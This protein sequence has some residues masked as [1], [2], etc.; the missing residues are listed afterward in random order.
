MFK[1]TGPYCL[2]MHSIGLSISTLFLAMTSIQIGASLAKQLFPIIGAVHTTALRLGIAS[3]ILLTIWRPWKLA[4]TTKQK[5]TIALYGSA[6]G[7]MNLCFYLAIERIP[8]G[9]AVSLEFCGPL[10]IAF[11]SS[12]RIFDFLFAVMAL[13]GILL[14]LPLHHS[15][16]LDMAGVIFALLAGACWALYVLF[17]NKAASSIHEG[18]ASA[19]G[20]AVASALII[21]LAIVERIDLAINSQI[22]PQA[23]LVALL[24]S[25]IP[26]SLEM[27]SLKRLPKQTFSILMSLEPALAAFTGYAF[28]SESLSFAQWLAIACIIIASLGTSLFAVKNRKT[29]LE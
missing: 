5:A 1:H 28:L 18:K 16:G 6:L 14:I 15:S 13:M 27:I 17:G 8:L 19:L 9:V 11:L 22:L 25:A 7:L 20:M 12:R 26:Y 24:S 3:I 4:L 21:P 2:T 29:A 23:F 10:A